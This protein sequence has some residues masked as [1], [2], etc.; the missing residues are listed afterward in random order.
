MF[1]RRNLRISWP[2]F[3][4][5]LVTRTRGKKHLWGRPLMCNQHFTVFLKRKTKQLLSK[6]ETNFF[7][8]LWKRNLFRA[9]FWQFI[10]NKV[11]YNLQFDIRR[12]NWVERPVNQCLTFARAFSEKLC[13]DKFFPWKSLFG[14][15]WGIFLF[16]EPACVPVHKLAKKKKL[17]NELE[18]PMFLQYAPH[19][20]S[21]SGM[22][23]VQR[24]RKE[25]TTTWNSV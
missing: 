17:N 21:I 15:Y 25:S 1:L 23:F 8:L 2:R 14:P 24:S 19:T 6:L 22:Y 5:T 18:W 11:K 13:D 9:F 7:A 4:V 16:P 10:E 20:S 12:T 3:H